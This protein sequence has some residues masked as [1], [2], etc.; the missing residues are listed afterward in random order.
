VKYI[1]KWNTEYVS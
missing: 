1:H